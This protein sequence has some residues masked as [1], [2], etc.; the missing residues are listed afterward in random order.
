[1]AQSTIVETRLF[2]TAEHHIGARYRKNLERAMQAIER[3]DPAAAEAELQPARAYCDAQQRPERRIVSVADAAEYEMYMASRGDDAPVEW[4]D[5]ACPAAYHLTG[6][7]HAG[8]R[9]MPEALAWLER[10]IAIAPYYPDPVNE[11]G[12]IQG[13]QGRLQE[14][15]ASYRAAIALA[16]AYP[17]AAYIKPMSLRGIGWVLVEMGDLDAA[18][19]AYE[20]SLELE[21][22]NQLAKS[23]LEY[24]AQLRARK[25]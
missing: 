25:P 7:L 17:N 2:G 8:A 19:Q 15:L 16:D 14:A 4:I 13:Q 23:E 20:T 3:G 11:R 5:I 21:P 12:F 6:Y 9:R 24:I 1:M 22:G 18:Q 10:A